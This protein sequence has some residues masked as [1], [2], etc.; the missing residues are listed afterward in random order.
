[1]SFTLLT[2]A[3]AATFGIGY[4]LGSR[5]T[6]TDFHCDPTQSED[7]KGEADDES[8]GD[9]AAI[10]GVGPCKLVLVV[11]GGKMAPGL[12]SAQ[13]VHVPISLWTSRC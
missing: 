7:S 10:K 13:Y 11:C 4:F 2:F 5:T 3:I 6:H 8:D 9:L 12:I 1:M